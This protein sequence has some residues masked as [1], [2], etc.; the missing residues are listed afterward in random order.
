MTDKK[1]SARDELA[2]LGRGVL[3][4]FLRDDLATGIGAAIGAGICL[5]L[6]V[7]VCLGVLGG[8]FL[9]LSSRGSV[10]EI[11]HYVRKDRDRGGDP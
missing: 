1:P 3:R 2:K 9:G 6:D 10:T 11:F 7:T 5:V 8:A 4:T